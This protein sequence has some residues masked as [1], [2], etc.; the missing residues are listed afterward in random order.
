MT[1]MYVPATAALKSRHELTPK[2]WFTDLFDAAA[3]LG[4][5]IRKIEPTRIELYGDANSS[6]TIESHFLSG[7][8]LRS[9]L[10]PRAD[11]GAVVE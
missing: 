10:R 7:R 5:S 1:N 9:V 8:M 11:P 6:I 3:D 4:L 2:E